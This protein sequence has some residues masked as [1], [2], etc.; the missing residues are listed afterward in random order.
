MR[1]ESEHGVWE[2]ALWM[3][4]EPAGA[5]VFASENGSHR[6]RPSG[7]YLPGVLREAR[8]ATLVFDAVAPAAAARRAGGVEGEAVG[9]CLHAACEW[10]SRHPAAADLPLGLAGVGRGATAALQVASERGRTVSAVV[11]RGSCAQRGE[12]PG[13]A[14]V[15]A[16]T[17]LIAGGLDD[18]AVACNRRAYAALRCK[19]R[20]EIVPGATAAFDEPGSLEV[21]ARLARN[22]FLQYL[23]Q[24]A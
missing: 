5:V 22:W 7:D 19:K 11:A 20:F 23:Y 6:L 2:A 16:P 18:P 3:P 8:L 1:I 12:L 13:I 14:G 21:V 24:Y 15:A 10:L 17:L 9:A 4:A